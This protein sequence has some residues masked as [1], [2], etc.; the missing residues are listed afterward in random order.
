MRRF[1]LEILHIGNKIHHRV[2]GP[3]LIAHIADMSA[4][5]YIKLQQRQ[6]VDIKI[7][8]SHHSH[9]VAGRSHNSHS[10]KH[11]AKRPL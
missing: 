2:G 10:V 3:H 6:Y 8:I 11:N 9:C 4:R 5:M 1:K 7:G